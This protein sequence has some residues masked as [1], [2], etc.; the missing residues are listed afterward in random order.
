MN[1][2]KSTRPF[3]IPAEMSFKEYC[4]Y[5]LLKLDKY[6]YK[7]NLDAGFCGRMW[8]QAVTILDTGATPRKSEQTCYQV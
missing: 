2:D 7:L 4:V 5:P 1:H 3:H 8:T 6:V